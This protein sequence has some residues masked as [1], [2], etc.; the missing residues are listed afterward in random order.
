MTRQELQELLEI[1]ISIRRK[2]GLQVFD[3]EHDVKSFNQ[4]PND[5]AI[6]R[7]FQI[8]SNKQNKNDDPI[9]LKCKWRSKIFYFG[10]GLD[11]CEN[12]TLKKLKKLVH[13]GQW[14]VYT[15]CN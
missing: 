12:I 11:E 2:K 1:P 6:I 8:Y 9:V 4:I 5:M 10:T 7:F 15:W 13:Q 14:Y 3:W